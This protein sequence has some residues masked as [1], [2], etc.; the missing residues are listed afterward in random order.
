MGNPKLHS[1]DT[2]ISLSDLLQ[3]FKKNRMRIILGTLLCALCGALY[4]L[5]KPIEYTAE[6]TFREKS[7]SQPIS[8]FLSNMIFGGSSGS[9]ASTDAIVMM[10]SR[11]FLEQLVRQ[12]ELHA[13]IDQKTGGFPTLDKIRKNITIERA[14]FKNSP[15]LPVPDPKPI[16]GVRAVA[17]E[18][19]VPTSMQI[20]FLSDSYFQ[21]LEEKKI[22]QTGEIGSPVT[23]G[24]I[25]FTLYRKSN[26]P[27]TN[28]E[29]N[30]SF[31]S[32]IKIAKNLS[33][34]MT[35]AVDRDHASVLKLKMNYPDRHQAATILNTLMSIYQGYLKDEQKRSLEEQ[36][37]Y[38]HDRQTEMGERLKKKMSDYADKLSSDAVTNG[39]F[40]LDQSMQFLT[41]MQQ[42][43]KGDLLGIDLRT[44]R[45]QAMQEDKHTY[46]G[47][48]NQDVAL[49]QI[50]TN[51]REYN[52]QFDSLNVA[53]HESSGASSEANGDFDKQFIELG[54]V[55]QFR[56]EIQ[57]ILK[58]LVTNAQPST[59]TKLWNDPRYLVKNWCEKL[60]TETGINSCRDNFISYL[61]NL[62]HLFLVQEKTIQER[63][64]HQQNLES[65]FRGI[66][67][68]TARDLYMQ[69]MRQVNEI[70]ANRLKHQFVIQEMEQPSFE[71]SSLSTLL[72]DHISQEMINKAS[73][74]T[75]LLQDQ[76]NRTVKE[77]ERLRDELSL[78]KGFLSIHIKQSIALMQLHEKLLHDKI[79]TLQKSRLAL[80]QQEISVLEEQ[81]SN[82]IDTSLE[83]LKKEK[84]VIEQH[85][86][87]VMQELAQLPSKWVEEKLIDH[88]MEMNQ[89]M[90]E[91]LSKLV[92][93]KNISSNL[94]LIHSS[95][96]DRAIPPLQPNSPHLLLFSTLGGILGA[97]MTGGFALLG[98]LSM[99]MRASPDNLRL[100][101]QHVS[102]TLSK[103]Y[104][105]DSKGQLRDQDLDTLRRLMAFMHVEKTVLEGSSMGKGQALLLVTSKGADYSL[106][107]ALLMARMG[108]KVVVLSLDF[109][110][111][112]AT[113][114]LPGLLHY[115]EGQVSLPKLHKGE[116]YDQIFSGGICRFASEL[117]ASKQF[118]QLIGE[119]E[120]RYDWIIAVSH[121]LPTSA[122]AECLL[123]RFD[124]AAFTVC[125][126]PLPEIEKCV[127]WAEQTTPK[128][129]ITFV[130]SP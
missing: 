43:Y 19:A 1:N 25:S 79:N 113:E 64:A 28:Q 90:V 124:R 70:E 26:A 29:Y 34:Q 36:I 127:N 73:A 11:K 38:L 87:A 101:D 83:N 37:G 65:E 81:L 92:E 88:E 5:T 80:L 84:N 110:R 35:L 56:A 128:K 125:D 53:L 63:L 96:L 103:Q 111:V 40:D 74:T 7:V 58:S 60:S 4:A 10:K 44:K 93:S 33:S 20:K 116:F 16:L 107:L 32:P 76:N 91:E 31:S 62:Q 72:H 69:Y 85:Q 57:E 100:A 54:E 130:F 27:L 6:A 94:E 109:N 129:A 3:V 12:L 82:Y 30:L 126:E 120:E 102:G 21:V 117:L 15:F 105:G 122:E 22:V 67:L 98:N 52:Q 108:L 50:L 23:V 114:E 71:L 95:P 97:L 121:A 75:L 78:Q 59:E 123:R 24:K 42:R 77:Q 8:N 48:D 112:A 55:Q 9:T 86:A 17:Y 18:E 49:N 68:G 45:F 13:Q 39:F 104:Q 106:D 99:G 41:E 61:T 2:L 118:S 66:D 14:A 115:L 89:S 51:I 47:T 119:L 46:H